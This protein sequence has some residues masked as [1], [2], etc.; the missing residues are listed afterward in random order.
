MI[1]YPFRRRIRHPFFPDL[2]AEPAAQARG[3]SKALAGTFADLSNAAARGAEARRAIFVLTSESEQLSAGERD[4]LWRLFQVPVYALLER[5]GRV[6]AWECEAQNG[7]HIAEG[8]DGST[9]AC[10]RPNAVMAHASA[11]AH[12]AD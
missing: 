9:C 10:G 2:A 5:G 1:F 7:L 4:E 11:L 6:E 12:A 3:R 8:G